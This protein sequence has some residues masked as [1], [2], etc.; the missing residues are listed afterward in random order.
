MDGDILLAV[1]IGVGLSA[2][3]GFRVFVPLLA[4]G[5]AALTGHL[6]LSPAFSWLGTWPAV[7][8]LGT[9]TFLEAAAYKVPW[10]DHAL[11]TVASPAAVLAGV[12]LTAS[13]L[14]DVS[15]AV[16]WGLAIIA[17]GGTAATV[18]AGTVLLR[19][20]STAATGGLGNPLVALLELVGAVL[21]SVLAILLPWIAL[22]LL[23]F[24]GGMVVA[25]LRRRVARGN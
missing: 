25:R 2:A 8:A 11:D 18:Q 21:T 15:P 22:G 13:L 5:L 23:L 3:A 19:G 20:A 17:G 12:L 4:A 14:G 16:R 24:L 1:V 10:L 7:A 9:A 6:H